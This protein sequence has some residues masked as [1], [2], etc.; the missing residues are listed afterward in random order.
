MILDVARHF[1][2]D[3]SAICL[4]GFVNYSVNIIIIATETRGNMSSPRDHYLKFT[5]S[6]LPLYSIACS[7]S[8]DVGLVLDSSASVGRW[9]FG[10]IK[11]F[12]RLIAR[13]FAISQKFGRVGVI[14]YGSYPRVE[15]GLNRYFNARHLDRTIERLR[16]I[17]G[18]RRTGKALE[19]A[20][21]G[22]FRGSRKKRVLIFVT[23]GPA[24]DGI[25]LPSLRIHQSGI[26]TFAIGIGSRSSHRE[27]SAI[28]TNARH[29][30]MVTFRTLKSIVKSIVRKACKGNSSKPFMIFQREI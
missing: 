29:T 24:A 22:L 21:S 10:Q 14:I 18:L 26:E 17:G 27:L 8:I 15:F 7:L 13:S 19:L 20:L 3:F 30:Y 1:S 2:S 16:L 28:A 23:N 12:A 9:G 5:L 11:Q 4:F 6:T 25:R